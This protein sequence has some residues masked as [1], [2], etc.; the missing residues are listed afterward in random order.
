MLIFLFP[1]LDIEQI[2]KT[3]EMAF[4]APQMHALSL[5]LSMD[6]VKRSQLLSVMV[7]ANSK[8]VQQI[9]GSVPGGAAAAGA[10]DD[11]SSAAGSSTAGSAAAGF[12]TAGSPAGSAGSA[13]DSESSGAS[14][15]R[16][17]TLSVSSASSEQ[18]RVHEKDSITK[19]ATYIAKNY[20]KSKDV[21]ECLYPTTSYM[22]N[23]RLLSILMKIKLLLNK[24]KQLRLQAQLD[25]NRV[26]FF[27]MIKRRISSAKE[28]RKVVLGNGKTWR[29]GAMCKTIDLS[30][31]D[32]GENERTESP[33]VKAESP[34]VNASSEDDGQDVNAVS[35]DDTPKHSTK[36]TRVQLAEEFKIEMQAKR[37]SKGRVKGKSG[38]RRKQVARKARGKGPKNPK[39]RKRK[40]GSVKA[41]SSAKKGKVQQP[42]VEQPEVNPDVEE[43]TIEPEPVIPFK[44]GDKVSAKWTGRSQRGKWFPGC[45]I[46]INV[47]KKTMHIEFDDGDHDK[48]VK[49][50]HVI[51][52]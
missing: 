8:T 1:L 30:Q 16:S 46:G 12:F 40:A 44:I 21:W 29:E 26:V 33:N 49:W 31:F 7:S 25:T 50:S 2:K 45:I 32:D 17:P 28:Y 3:I 24:R 41:P 11:G 48:K 18:Q 6:S 51:L 37:Q 9:P 36:A 13:F 15:I 23:G 42:E 35:E 14:S 27:R 22:H 47:E 20:L 19:L 5:L 10:F 43:A 34:N 52:P 38:R 39:S 4:T